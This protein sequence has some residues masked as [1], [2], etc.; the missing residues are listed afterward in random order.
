MTGT[1]ECVV[2][3]SEGRRRDVI[4]A[5]ADSA[6]P[7]LLDVHSDGDHNR[8]VLT[9]AGPADALS[10]GVRSL[11]AAAVARLDLNDHA[12]VHPRIGVLDVVPWITL[13][14]WP[15]QAG[16]PAP[17]LTARDGFARWAG[18]RLALPCFLYGPERSLPVLRRQ[19]WISL[20]PDTGPS[21]AHPSAGAAAVGARGLLVA[22]NLWLE[23]CNLDLARSIAADLRRPGVRALGLSVGGAVQVSCNLTEP[24]RLGPAA[25]FDAVSS[26]AAVARAEL[27]GLLPALV[28]DATPE[29]R[30]PELDLD[31]SRTIEARLQEA[32]LDG[33]SRVGSEW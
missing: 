2:N 28:L 26:R 18:D 12:G 15:L 24:L 33:G 10:D 14:G 23:E 7:C 8:S 16:P 29:R 1:L 9:L 32:G 21:E 11:A 22:Y 25:V 5:L 30:W 3:V 20:E 17:A 27:V 31:R 19:A 4:A 13:T 6:G